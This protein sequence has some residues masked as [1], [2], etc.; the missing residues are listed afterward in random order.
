MRARL[1]DPRRAAKMAAHLARV[2]EQ[3]ATV[4]AEISNLEEAADE[5]ATKTAAWGLAR[6]DKAMA[7]L[8]TRIQ[9]LRGELSGL[10]APAHAE[11]ATAD[12]VRT[13]EKAKAAGDFPA[14][15][16]MIKRAFPKLTL[17]PSRHFNDHSPDRIV[18]EPTTRPGQ[19]SDTT[20]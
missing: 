19:A 11:A 1:G 3:R 13:W 12:A 8:L 6:V 16:A 17:T 9:T 5:L 15:R 2:S 20:A 18:W 7:P 4:E 14:M 10:E